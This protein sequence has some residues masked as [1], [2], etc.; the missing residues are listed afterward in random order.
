[1][2]KQTNRQQQE[3]E[4]IFKLCDYIDGEKQRKLIEEIAEPALYKNDF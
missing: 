1:M 4:Y 2:T 3:E